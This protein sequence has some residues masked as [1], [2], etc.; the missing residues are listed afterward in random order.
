MQRAN[1]ELNDEEEK[2]HIVLVNLAEKPEKVAAFLADNDIDLT[3][4][5]EGT[6]DEPLDIRIGIDR[7]D[8]VFRR[9]KAF[10]LPT[11]YAINKDGIITA[12]QV[13]P[14]LAARDLANLLKAIAI[15]WQP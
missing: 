9:Y 2:F 11:T 1:E 13:G 7:A 8:S 5:T 6:G 15:D 10:G 3:V 12:K 4:A 14:F